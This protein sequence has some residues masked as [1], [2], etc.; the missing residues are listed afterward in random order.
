MTDRA[1]DL[2]VKMSDKIVLQ[3][4]KKTEKSDSKLFS[5]SD[6]LNVMNNSKRSNASEI[7]KSDKKQVEEKKDSKKTD[8]NQVKAKDEKKKSDV[9][10]IDNKNKKNVTIKNKESDQNNTSKKKKGILTGKVTAYTA[11][12][13]AKTA[14]GHTPTVGVCAMNRKYL[15]RKVRLTVGNYSEDF[16]VDDTGGAFNRQGS[17]RILDIYMPNKKACYNWGVRSGYVEFLD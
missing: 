11:S 6:F 10:K 2:G 4:S 7:T 9:S 15:G 3:D 14:R 13:G 17:D 5:N 8:V 12:R 16:I 1:E